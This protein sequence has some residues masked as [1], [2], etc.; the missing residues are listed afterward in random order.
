MASAPPLQWTPIGR[1]VTDTGRIAQIPPR[2]TLL[3]ARAAR[4]PQ[5]LGHQYPRLP[6]AWQELVI[7]AKILPRFLSS[8]PITMGN[9]RMAPL[10]WPNDRGKLPHDSSPLA[11]RP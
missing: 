9:S 7:V 2:S 11:W 8:G 10:L 1:T 5:V 4:R 3:D 6:F